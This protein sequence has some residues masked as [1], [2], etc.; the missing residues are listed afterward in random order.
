MLFSIVEN[1]ICLAFNDIGIVFIMS[2]WAEKAAQRANEEERTRKL[3][4][5]K[6]VR[7]ANI[8]DHFGPELVTQLEQCLASQ[9]KKYNEIRGKLELHLESSAGRDLIS[10][11]PT[12]Q[13]VIRQAGNQPRQPMK[14]TYS[15]SAHVLKYDCGIY[16]ETFFMVVGADGR[17]YFEVPANHTGK[18][19]EDIGEEILSRFGEPRD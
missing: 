13:I 14:I 11:R 7:D 10:P 5:E 2:D 6:S 12:R 15:P 19:V 16:Q 1:C 3:E 8:M 18:T 4:I 9:I 17:G